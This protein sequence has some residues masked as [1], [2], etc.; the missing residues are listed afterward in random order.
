MAAFVE[1][2]LLELVADAL[3]RLRPGATAAIRRDDQSSASRSRALAIA[4]DR[5]AK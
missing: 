3:L 5:S 2:E 1:H 4:L